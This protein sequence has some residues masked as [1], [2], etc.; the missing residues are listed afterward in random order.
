M[1]FRIFTAD[2]GKRNGVQMYSAYTQIN[3]PTA[4]AA[5]AEG[6]QRFGALVSKKAPIKAI[7]WPPDTEE[8]KDWLENH[9]G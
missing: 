1:M 2:R 6:N 4:E 3:A 8:S 9:V 7:E 5:E